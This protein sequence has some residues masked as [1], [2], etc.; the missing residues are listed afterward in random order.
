MARDPRCSLTCVS[1]ALNFNKLLL[2]PPSAWGTGSGI[3]H[4]FCKRIGLSSVSECSLP[5]KVLFWCVN[6]GHLTGFETE[7]GRCVVFF[8]LTN[9]Q[10][11]R[12]QNRWLSVQFEG[13]VFQLDKT[14]LH[15]L[16]LQK[17]LQVQHPE[18]QM[19]KAPGAQ[20]RK[21]FVR[22]AVSNILR[23]PGGLTV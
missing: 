12:R 8:G 15:S 17:V 11:C 23:N 18:R 14:F 2:V 6:W 21:D 3:C 7:K 13:Y 20:N 10:T 22:I 16:T 9:L 1:C 5:H 19:Q 4:V